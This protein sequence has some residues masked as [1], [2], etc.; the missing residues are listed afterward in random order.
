GFANVTALVQAAG[1][2]SYEIANVQAQTGSDK[3][4]GWSLVVVYRD[5]LAPARNL[6]VF[7]GYAVVQQT[8]TSDQ[9]VSIP[10]SGFLAPPS[11]AVN[12]SVGVIAYEGDR[13]LTGDA[14]K[15]NST[16]L[17]NSLNPADNFFNSSITSR[18]AQ[19]TN[20]TPNYVNQLGFDA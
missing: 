6:T 3:Y 9:K 18:G 7:D 13:G 4:A 17:T 1:D 16:T 12:A 5:P 14:L 15:L 19:F 2:G 11:G 8:P 10:V 20:K